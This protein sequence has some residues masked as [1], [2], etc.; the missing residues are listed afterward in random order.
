MQ[1]ACKKLETDIKKAGKENQIVPL[2]SYF[3]VV[4][5]TFDVYYLIERR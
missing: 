3:I 4:L 1:R 2:L 5:V